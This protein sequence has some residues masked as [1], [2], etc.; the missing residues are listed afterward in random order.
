M[1]SHS[2][3]YSPLFE[4]SICSMLSGLILFLKYL[5]YLSVLL[6]NRSWMLI[7]NNN[8]ILLLCSPGVNHRMHLKNIDYSNSYINHKTGIAERIIII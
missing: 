8:N 3:D 6:I 5:T 2:G 1:L 7:D 4:L